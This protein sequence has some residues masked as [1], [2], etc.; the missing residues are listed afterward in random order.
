MTAPAGV[1]PRVLVI[2]LAALGDF[3]QAFGPF[4][5]IRA[6]HP[7]AAITLLTTPP[8]A[9]LARRSPWF[10]EVWT[11]GRPS[12]REPAAVRRL[13]DPG[14][15]LDLGQ[16]YV[17]HLAGLDGVG[18]NLV[19]VLAAYNAGP[20]AV[21]KARGVPPYAETRAYVGRVLAR[22]LAAAREPF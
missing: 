19:R 11:D 14:L 22:W 18:G 16:R 13:N 12:W 6:H 8:Y 4:A 2:K 1:R 20:G 21:L 7:D 15:S 3:V 10:D 5:A 9:A 17:H